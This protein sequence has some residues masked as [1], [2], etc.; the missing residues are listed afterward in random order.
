MNSKIDAYFQI[1]ARGTTVSNEFRGAATTFL[2][3]SYILLVNPQV[4]AKVGIPPQEVGM[5]LLLDM[6]LAA[7]I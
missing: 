6:S 2:T 5:Y 4:L 3:M 1:S 7:N